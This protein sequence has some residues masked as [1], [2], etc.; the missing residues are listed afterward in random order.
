MKY[1]R[2]N[3]DKMKG[4]IPGIQP[5]EEGWLKLNTNESS[6]PPSP[7]ALGALSRAIN[8]SLALYPSPAADELRKT[9][10]KTYR[11]KSDMVLVGNG[12]DEVLS[13]IARSFLEKGKKALILHPTYSLFETI[14]D[15]QGAKLIK[16]KLNDDFTLPDRVFTKKAD[17]AFIANPNP[18]AGTLFSKDEMER[19]ARRIGGIL[20]IDE[21]YVDFSPRNCLS[22]VSKYKNIIVTRT[23]SKSYSLAGMRIGFAIAQKPVIDG[24]M[25]V[26]DSYNVNRLSQAVAIAA[27]EDR[28]YFRKSVREIIRQRKLMMKALKLLGFEVMPSA[29]NFI[30]TKPPRGITARQLY[31]ALLERKVLIRYFDTKELRQ[32]VRITVGNNKQNSE[33]LNVIKLAFEDFNVD[34][35]DTTFEIVKF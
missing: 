27:L 15:I 30:L 35:P 32:Y 1:F 33:M 23:L 18:Q 34:C 14:V 24:M 5:K 31:R 26:K 8:G 22:L 3:I 4:Y 20:V 9:V 7:A 12:S 10:A 17:C 6:F 11:I 19:L 13:I 2:E 16:Q 21:A 25:K 28:L 29:S